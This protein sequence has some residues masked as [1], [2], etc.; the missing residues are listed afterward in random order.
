MIVIFL[1]FLSI[2]VECKKA[3][4]GV[5]AVALGTLAG[6]RHH[7]QDFRQLGIL[8]HKADFCWKDNYGRG[9]GRIP[10]HCEQGKERKGLLCHDKCKDGYHGVGFLCWENCP[11]GYEKHG[12]T[13]RRFKPLHITIRKR[14][15][16]GIGTPMIC[17]PGMEN[18]GGLCYKTCK[19]GYVGVGPVCWTKCVAPYSHACGATCTVTAGGC[20]REIF[21]ITAATAELMANVAL[22]VV[23]AGGLAAGV[24]ASHAAAAAAARA[25]VVAASK[26]G[27][28]TAGRTSAKGL[29]KLSGRIATDQVK[30]VTRQVT[31]AAKGVWDVNSASMKQDVPLLLVEGAVLGTPINWADM[32]PTGVA[33]VIQN[34]K[35]PYCEI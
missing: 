8:K 13:C 2:I 25:G 28:V 15:K 4:T 5:A 18:N 22:M 21:K 31:T 32:D 29:A 1:V 7:I 17:P 23:T 16:R 24:A 34:L 30:L 35:R 14:Y 10:S 12:L 9:I 26:A 20:A 3:A 27:V 6:N 11:Q 33:R 19:D